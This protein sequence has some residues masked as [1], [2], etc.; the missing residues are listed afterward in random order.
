[1]TKGRLEAF[2]DGVFAVAITLLILGVRPEDGSTGWQIFTQEWNHILVYLLSF[3]LVGVYWVTHH[4]MMHF[5]T[6]INRTLLWLNLMLL[7]F[8]AFIPF[9]A[10]QLSASHADPSSIRI[11]ASTLILLNLSGTSLMAYACN[12]H[13][14]VSPALPVSFIRFMLGLYTAPVPVYAAAIALA[15][16]CSLAS[17]I[18]MA[19]VPAFFVLPNPWIERRMHHAMETIREYEEKHE[20][21]ED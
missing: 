10:A 1:M 5:V 19:L 11:Y 2:S 21:P 6:G 13:R 15:S 8:I 3:V 20:Q 12:N 18:L 17:M 14:L 4:N 7:L 16:W 9:A